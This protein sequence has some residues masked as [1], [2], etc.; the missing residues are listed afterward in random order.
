MTDKPDGKRWKWPTW[1]CTVLR[2]AA[3]MLIV[4]VASLPALTGDDPQPA[5]LTSR[6]IDEASKPA[7]KAIVVLAD[8]R[9][10][11]DII[12]GEVRNNVGFRV[13]DEAGR[14]GFRPQDGD[15][16]F[17]VTHPAGYAQVKC[18]HKSVPKSIQLNPWARVEG[19][20]RVAR[21]PVANAAIRCRVQDLP[22]IWVYNTSTT[23]LNG[24]FVFERSLPGP[25]SV[26][27]NLNFK[28]P[29]ELSSTAE[30]RTKLTAG[31]TARID[32]GATGR[33]VVGQL[34]HAADSKQETPWNF[35]SIQVAPLVHVVQETTFVATIDRAGNFRIDDVPPGNYVLQ[36]NFFKRAAEHLAGHRFTVP[37]IND[38]FAQRPVDLG[39]LT[40]RPGGEGHFGPR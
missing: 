18:S 40:L 38:K 25:A 21:K 26:R 8:A 31:Q 28:V 4:V 35:A 24:R 32:F 12:N 10:Q 19:T 14:F 30:I 36:V 5:T 33:P 11:I 2:V 23:D 27:R 6:V 16:W 13:T 20:F 37:E 3:T 17:V 34:E 39:V 1:I 22:W 15:F 9:S 7:S 29:I